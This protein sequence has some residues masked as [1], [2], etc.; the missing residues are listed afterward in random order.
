M[1]GTQLLGRMV[2]GFCSLVAPY[3][4]GSGEELIYGLVHAYIDCVLSFHY[5]N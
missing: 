4:R 5:Y 1:L 2:V 3:P